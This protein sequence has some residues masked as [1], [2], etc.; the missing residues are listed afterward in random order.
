MEKNRIE[1]RY[2]YDDVE[3]KL[4]LPTN[5]TMD[6]LFEYLKVFCLAVGYSP[7]TVKDYFNPEE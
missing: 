4:I 1:L 3:L 2:I 7:D 5:L 6:D